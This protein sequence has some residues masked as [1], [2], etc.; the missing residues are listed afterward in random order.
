METVG[1]SACIGLQIYVVECYTSAMR[2]GV[3]HQLLLAAPLCLHACNE[4]YSKGTCS[5]K[6]AAAMRHIFKGTP[7]FE[8]KEWYR[9]TK[10]S[11]LAKRTYRRGGSSGA[12]VRSRS[13]RGAI[14]W[15]S[16]NKQASHKPARPVPPGTPT[17]HGWVLCP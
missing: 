10:L 5:Y 2:F 13:R 7:T 4:S 16:G 1:T 8:C 12:A 6:P 11:F 15:A 3:K 14:V 9:A 17:T